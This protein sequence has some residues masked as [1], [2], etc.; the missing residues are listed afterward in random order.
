MLKRGYVGVYHNMS[1]KHL[2]IREFEGRHNAHPADS[3]NHM[4]A[5]AQGAVGKHLAYCK[6][7]QD[8]V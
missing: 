8:R 3:I 7:I 1:V 6:L 4:V 5:I 2:H